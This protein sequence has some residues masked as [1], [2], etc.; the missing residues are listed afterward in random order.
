MIEI[1]ELT[2]KVNVEPE[3]GNSQSSNSE[4]TPKNNKKSNLNI[5]DLVDQVFQIIK[6]KKER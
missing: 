1:K 6:N 2:I 4:K 5:D 3:S